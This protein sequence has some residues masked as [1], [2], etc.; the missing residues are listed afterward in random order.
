MYRV[1]YEKGNGKGQMSTSHISE[2]SF[3]TD[4]NETCNLEL[5]PPPSNT[6]VQNLISI[7]RRDG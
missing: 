7:R 5:P 6:P 3:K 2:T 1:L 4:C